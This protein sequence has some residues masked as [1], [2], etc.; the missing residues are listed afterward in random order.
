M[1]V[2]HID[3]HGHIVLEHTP[4]GM[5]DKAGE[6]E[7][8]DG[9]G[10]FHR[11]DPGAVVAAGDVFTVLSAANTGPGSTFVW[12][13]SLSGD[14]P[15]APSA[16]GLRPKPSD[17]LALIRQALKRMSGVVVGAMVVLVLAVA[18]AVLL[19]PRA[20]DSLSAADGFFTALVLMT[21]GT[22]ADLFPAFHHLS[23]AIRLFSIVLSVIGTVAVGLLYAW[24]TERLMTLRL[25][26]LPRRPRPPERDHVVIVGLGGVGRAAATLLDEL[27]RAAVG[28][29]PSDLL[30]PRTLPNLAVVKGNGNDVG[31]LRE[32]HLGEARGL[33][34]ATNND[35][36]NLEIALVARKLNPDCA[37]V[38]RTEDTRFSDN[39][40]DLVPGLR[41]LCIPVIAASAFAA[42]ALGE[43]VIDL[44]QLGRT[45]VFVV[46]YRIEAEDALRGS[47]LAEVAEGY[48]VVP[49]LHARQDHEAR[50]CSASDGSIRLQLGDRLA[51][52]AACSI[53]S[54]ARPC[55]AAARS[56]SSTFAP[57]PSVSFLPGC[58][59]SN[60]ATLSS[61]RKRC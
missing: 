49:I 26:L 17:F 14:A 42:A 48:A 12:P 33:L 36:M 43:N 6:E 30:E 47:T 1:R 32:A 22:Y 55:H 23:N 5:I 21:G 37:M 28:V 39:V 25:R 19:F 56:P 57:M 24:F 35:W 13:G 60:S 50:P 16:A 29:E 45:T 3:S 8:A 7:A 20:D 38:I 27:G 34:A 18:L 31:S 4:K 11:Y 51:V 9:E 58:S 40:T 61:T 54:A 46:E 53:S 52:L 10:P 44:F 41:V 15:R 2:E 59:S